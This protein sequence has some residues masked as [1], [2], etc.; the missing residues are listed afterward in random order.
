MHRI[1]SLLV[2]SLLAAAGC[3]ASPAAPP[4]PSYQVVVYGDSTLYAVANARSENLQVGVLNATT[5]APVSGVTVEWRMVA[6]NAGLGRAQSVSDDAGLASTW[7]TGAAEGTYRVEATT[8]RLQGRAASISIR[9]VPPPQVAAVS[10]ASISAGGEV[11]VS[12]ANFSADPWENAV[13]FD[14]VRGQVLSGSTTELRVRVPACLPSREARISVGLGAVMTAGMPVAVSGTGGTLVEL[15]PGG[16]RTIDQPEELGC[17]RL[18]GNDASAWVLVVHA[19][20]DA[21]RPPSRFQL[22]GLAPQTFTTTLAV[23]AVGPAPAF[24]SGWEASLRV[25]ERGLGPVLLPPG[26]GLAARTPLPSVGTE[27]QFNVYREPQQF[28]RIT[29]S[30]RVVG[31]RGIIYV[32]NEAASEFTEDDLQYFAGLFDDPIHSALVD[33]FGEPSDLDGNDRVIILF[34]PR[35]NALTP[36]GSGSF[37]S[38]FFYGCDLVSRDRCSGTNRGEIFYAMV[39]DP[40]G[41]WGD[42]RSRV[43]VRAAVPPVLAHEFQHMIHFARRGFSS[44]ALWLSEG[45]AHTAEELVADVF[46]AR[47]QHTLAQSFRSPNHGRAQQYLGNPSAVSVLGE[48]LPGS[49]AQRGAAWLLVRYARGHHGGTDLLRRLTASTRS[50]VA[51][52]VHETGRPWREL[53]ADFG[54]ALWAADAPDLEGPLDERY[55]FPG[56]SPRQALSPVPGA[57]PL[58]VSLLPWQE[59]MASGDVASGSHRFFRVATPSGGAVPSVTWMLAGFRGVPLDGSSGLALSLV[60]VR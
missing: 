17:L 5:G 35:V 33:V 18:P 25:Q 37:V 42:A 19:T 29:A 52:I 27:R 40:T 45:L 49:I 30:A 14:G 24:Q 58:Q 55:T 26:E 31:S 34:T 32:D 60:R 13:Y 12:G 57:Y 59:V 39:P 8:A 28:S 7:L 51:N 1:V 3:R 36:R 11:V 23:P 21:A 15:V 4:E 38:G 54:V 6:G 48:D 47:D 41:R 56:F 9:V 16:V 22:R 53:T 10:P 44:D 43:A 46:E 2:L 20:A 50:S